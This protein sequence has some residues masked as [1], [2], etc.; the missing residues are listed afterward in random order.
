MKRM[1]WLAPASALALAA[2]ALFASHVPASLAQQGQQFPPSS[3]KPA[4]GCYVCGKLLAVTF[5]D[6]DCYGIL[7]ADACG[8]SL[9]NMPKAKRESFCQEVKARVGFTSFKDSCPVYAPYCGSEKT[10]AQGP[11]SGGAASLPT[12]PD[13]DGLADGFGGPPPAPPT[14]QLSPPRL[15]YLIM[16]VPGGGKPVTAFTVFLDRAA[17]LLPLAANNQPS[18]PAAAKHV[19]R[20]RIMH[21][22]G[23]VRIEAEASALAGGAKLGPVTGE[24]KGEDAAAVTKATR[25]LTEKM[26]LVCAR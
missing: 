15:V 4:C 8:E 17:C 6:K 11:A 26:K 3:R 22:D 1:K 12:N 19:V 5:E 7:A 23:R 2:S 25:V 13:H 16:G 20:G 9:A 18:E 14:G 10:A 24:A 21:G